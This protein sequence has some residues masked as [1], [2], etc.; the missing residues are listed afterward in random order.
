MRWCISELV[1]NLGFVL[2]VPLDLHS[3]LRFRLHNNGTEKYQA[4][5]LS[6]IIVHFVCLI[7]KK[8]SLTVS[9]LCSKQFTKTPGHYT[10]HHCSIHFAPEQSFRVIVQ[11]GNALM[12]SVL[13]RKIN[14]LVSFYV[15]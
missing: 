12:M 6:T 13:S 11:I 3:S 2:F 5:C 1:H 8:L 7:S 4:K 9:D 10:H 14:G 15:N